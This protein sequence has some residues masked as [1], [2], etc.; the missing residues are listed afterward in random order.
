MS[1]NLAADSA[2]IEALLDSISSTSTAQTMERVNDLVAML[3][4]LYGEGLARL[5]RRIEG[6]DREALAALCGDELVT[7]LLVL[8][9]I[10]PVPLAERIERALEPLRDE[11]GAGGVAVSSLSGDSLELELI[12][13]SDTDPVLA[14][15]RIEAAIA[16]AA[17][18]IAAVA[19]SA[20][21][22]RTGGEHESTGRVHLP[23]LEER[24]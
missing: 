24:R 18:E 10:H 1:R 6:F 9:G 12:T 21:T 14:R 2:R 5:V 20:A 11:L 23:V 15:Q 7:G 3:V 8:H 16:A 4:D 19:C 22:V 13:D 17:P